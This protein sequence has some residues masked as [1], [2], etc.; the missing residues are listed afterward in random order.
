MNNPSVLRLIINLARNI[1]CRL[2][3]IHCEKFMDKYIDG[4]SVILISCFDISML[5]EK[6]HVSM[7]D[8][9]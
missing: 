5:S 4:V 6:M 1:F 9:S 8:K 3:I 7:E 2:S